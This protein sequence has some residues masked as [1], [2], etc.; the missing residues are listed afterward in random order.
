L[1]RVRLS[2]LLAALCATGLVAAGCGSS[3]DGGDTGTAATTAAAPAETTTT[4]SGGAAADDATNLK[5]VCPDTVVIQTDWYP[6]SDHSEAYAIAGPD[7]DYD[8]SKKSYTAP[9]MA[10]GKDTGVKVEVRA[11]GPAIGFQQVSAQMYTDPSI[12]LGYV[13]TDEAV[14]LSGKQPT[15]AVMAPRE[16]W[17]QVL[18]YAPEVYDFKTIA[19]IG[20]T[21]TTVLYFEGNSYMKY[22]TGAG[23]LKTSQVDASYDGT[24]A[25]FVSSGGKVVQQGFITAEPWQY[26]HTVKPWMKPVKTLSIQE[27]GYPNYGETLA[28]TP[29]NK[30]KYDGCLK[31]LI[32]IIQQAQVDYA[33]DPTATNAIIVKAAALYKGWDYPAALAAYAA[34]AQVD[35]KIISNGSDDT[36]GDLDEARVQK[37]I[38]ITSPIFAKQNIKVKDG[39][40]PADIMTNEYIQ[41]GIGL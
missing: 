34:K 27:A 16:N 10:Q 17:A 6:E 12:L 3:D 25:R 1:S 18:I 4:A 38:D 28:V 23:I 41:K 5:G 15:I 11:G 32:P 13:N 35:N 26:E 39:L 36:L 19:D 40:T 30:T 33:K 37:M 29:D 21:D 20:K 31:K 24:P 7:G 9:L 22:L 8:A 2:T 14:M